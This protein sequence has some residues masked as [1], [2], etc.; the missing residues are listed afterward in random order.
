LNRQSQ[1][2][3]VDYIPPQFVRYTDERKLVCRQ[4]WTN[5]TGHA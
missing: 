4:R 2:L 5:Y 3:F 1:A